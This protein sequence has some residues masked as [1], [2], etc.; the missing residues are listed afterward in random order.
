MVYY[1]TISLFKKTPK[2]E[3]VCQG[4]VLKTVYQSSSQDTALQN[5]YLLDEKWGKKYPLAI[6]PWLTNWDNLSCYFKFSP[7]IRRLI[8]TT[9]PI[10]GFHR[11][12]RKYTKTKGAF[13]SEMALLK[14]VYCAIQNIKEK[15]TMCL[16]NWAMT[17]SQLDIYF[18]GR[19]KLT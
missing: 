11:Q 16:R 7:D 13:T 14:L 4:S 10:E 18:P 8:Y 15:W 6:K 17:L 1:L 5:L 3:T 19:L 12:V 2:N 9:N